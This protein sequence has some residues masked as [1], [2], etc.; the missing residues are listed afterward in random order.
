M[1]FVILNII[2]QK[3]LLNLFIVILLQSYEERRM[4]TLKQIELEKERL[5]IKKQST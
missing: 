2:G 3:I 4:E 1:Y 5:K